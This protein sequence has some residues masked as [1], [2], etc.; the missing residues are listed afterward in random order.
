MTSDTTDR[1]NGEELQTTRSDKPLTACPACGCRDLFV[2]KD[3]PQKLGLAIVVIA[4]LA[5]LA[6]AA[7]PRTFY[8]GVWVLVG[9]AVLDGLLYFFVPRV[10]VCYRCRKEFRRVPIN[11]A[12]EGFE[13]A[14]AEKYRSTAVHSEAAA[15]ARGDAI[16]RQDAKTPR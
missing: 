7:R 14:V 11:P 12:H 9:A 6:L 10:T 8:L 15:S 4:G 13:L 1:V 5:F 2:R 3:F 16:E